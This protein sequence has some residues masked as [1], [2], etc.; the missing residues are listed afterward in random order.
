MFARVPD[1]SK[2][3][4]VRLVR[5]LQRREFRLID[6]QVHTAH[7]ASLGA[8]TVPRREFVRVLGESCDKDAVPGRWSLE[9]QDGI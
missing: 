3:A 5:E 1:A 4:F 8:V 9:R 7:L 6:C 2:V